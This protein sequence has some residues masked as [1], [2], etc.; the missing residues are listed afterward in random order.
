VGH[1]E[2]GHGEGTVGGFEATEWTDVELK[3]TIEPF[4]NLFEWSELSRCF[5][6]VLEASDL[7]ESDLMLFVAFFVEEHG[8]SSIRRVGVGD[9]CKFLVG[10][11]GANSFVHGN[12][13]G[14][15]FAI[16][17]DEVGRD[18]VLL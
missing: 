12:G 3:S 1:D 18:G 11:S 13:G 4:N 16:I 17:R 10:F 15:S 2:R 5:V 7:F 14:Q 9:E 6:E 8:A